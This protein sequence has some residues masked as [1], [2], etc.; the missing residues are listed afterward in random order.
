M[1]GSCTQTADSNRAL[2][3]T[4]V[5]VTVIDVSAVLISLS[6]IF[7]DNF[8]SRNQNSCVENNVYLT[9]AARGSVVG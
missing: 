1:Q 8:K 2:I 4:G 5:L 9:E 3:Q 7:I 6:F